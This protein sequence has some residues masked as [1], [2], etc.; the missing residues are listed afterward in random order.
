[1]KI[2]ML[3]NTGVGKTTYMASLYGMMQQ[4]IKGFSL[5]AVNTLDES[6]L[7]ELAKAISQ[8]RYPFATD[9][10]SEYDFTLQ[11]QG[12]SVLQFC[13]SD[14]RGGAIVESQSSEQ[15]QA[16]VQDLQSA[17]GIMMFCD[18]QAL[19]TGNVRASE[20]R[21]MTTLVT[22]A[23]QT[24]DHPI[25]LAIVL[26][27]TD[28][29]SAFRPEWFNTFKGL[30]SVISASEWVSGSVIPI[31]CGTQFINV[32]MPLL[33]ALYAAA[34]TRAIYFAQLT[35]IYRTHAQECQ[36]RSEGWIGFLRSVR[37]TWNGAPTDTQ[38]AHQA[39]ALAA[40]NSQAFESIREPVNSL[41]EYVREFPIIDDSKSPQDYA[42]ACTQLKL[43]QQFAQTIQNSMS[44]SFEA[45]H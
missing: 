16:L 12:K 18:C 28:Q 9:Q 30:M 8:G 13:W 11:Y 38:M 7:L 19:S 10:R 15:A 23:L 39:L 4:R 33:F 26:T 35:E 6:G 29:I 22:Q 32:P 3:G 42:Q 21:R 1:M 36:Q 34:Y 5:K 20:I 44:N 45:F 27:K 31:A 25:A 40:E 43:Y 14:Y 17:D 37:D 41:I 24:V 2:V